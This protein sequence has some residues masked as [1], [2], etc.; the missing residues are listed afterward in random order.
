MCGQLGP[1]ARAQEAAAQEVE[2]SAVMRGRGALDWDEQVSRW[3]LGI[4]NG[5]FSTRSIT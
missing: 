4:W 5:K 2:A 1:M 3:G